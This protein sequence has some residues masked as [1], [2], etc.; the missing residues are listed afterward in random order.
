MNERDVCID[1]AADRTWGKQ[2][3]ADYLGTTVGTLS[4]WVSQRRVPFVRVNRKIRF[5]KKDLDA[6]LDSNAVE[7]K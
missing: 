1:E 2:Q 4:V 5:R 6:W 7:P 3:T